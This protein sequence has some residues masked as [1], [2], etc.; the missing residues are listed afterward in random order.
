MLGRARCKSSAPA[1]CLGEYGELR[2]AGKR[3]DPA[4]S[5]AGPG[6]SYLRWAKD[7]LALAAALSSAAAVAEEEEDSKDDNEPEKPIVTKSK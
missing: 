7:A 5:S 4:E 3:P 2:F 1:V 6:L